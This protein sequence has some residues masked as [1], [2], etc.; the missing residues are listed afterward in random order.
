MSEGRTNEDGVATA[1]F[2]GLWQARCQPCV[3]SQLTGGTESRG[4]RVVATTTGGGGT[5]ATATT[6]GTSGTGGGGATTTAGGGG[7]GGCDGAHG[8]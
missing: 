3:Q 5:T 6:G 1:V 4:G 7:G 8:R 2:L